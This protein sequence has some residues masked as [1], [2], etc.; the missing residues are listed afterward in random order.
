MKKIYFFGLLLISTFL[1]NA[2]DTL[3]IEPSEVGILNNTIFGDTTETGE[4]Q[5]L[6]RV[7]VLRRGA[8]YLI[9][10]MIRWSD[11]HIHI[12]AE[13]GEGAR[14]LILFNVDAG[15]ETLDQLFRL[16][17]GADL[18]VKGL[19]ISCKDILGNHV[20]RG[21]RL[22]GDRS[23]VVVDDCIIEEAGQSAFRLN[24]DSIKVYVTNSLINRIGRPVDPNNGRF[25]DNRGHP[26]D[27]LWIENSIV[28]D[29]TSRYYRNGGSNP[30]IINGIFNQNTF[31]GSGQLSFSFGQVENLIFTNNIVANSPFLGRD[32]GDITYTIN[33][34]TFDV[35]TM[36][37]TISH[38]NIFWDP[39]VVAAI[40]DTSALGDTLIS[41]EGNLFNEGAQAA[42]DSAETEGTIISE[43]LTFADAPPFP[44]ML[45]TAVASDT[46]GQ[47]DGV[48]N[49]G[50]WD[51]SDLTPD[52]T[53][54]AI[55]TGDIPRY[56]TYHDFTYPFGTASSTAGTEGQ[57]LGANPDVISSAPDVFVDHNILY[58]PNPARH[59]LF[60]QNLDNVPLQRIML[61]SLSG[62]VLQEHL[63]VDAPTF[64]LSLANLAR[65]TYILSLVDKS[66]QV[67]SRKVIKF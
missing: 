51:F 26:I 30:K 23:K 9:T 49:A 22:S 15:G 37:V 29:V 45:I 24:A 44:D 6:N 2:Q 60:V 35:A 63:Q 4:R 1:L 59:E 52:A 67:S 17:D 36:D 62:Q 57:P 21:I 33:L 8:P 42:V 11:Y 48:P 25:L 10:E 5:N 50:E 64:R 61:F 53:Y 46:T 56:T 40:P 27:T 16:D 31:W 32:T 19:H 39:E 41:M 14:P 54:S 55:G 58:Y 47:S 7:Y 20:T 65:G 34:D 3:I 18:T 38:N 12:V 66:G 13:E 43:V 28:Y